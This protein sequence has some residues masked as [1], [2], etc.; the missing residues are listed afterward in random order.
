LLTIAAAALA[1]TL[2][3]TSSL[4]V[5]TATWTVM[6]G[7]RS[8]GSSSS[9]VMKDTKTG[10]AFACS[11]S[12]LSATFKSGSGL[13]GSDLG[14]VTS[15]SATR[16]DA[17]A[18]YGF[19]FSDLPYVFSASSYSS[20]TTTGRITGIHAMGTGPGCTFVMDGTGATADN[21]HMVVTYSN[22]T[23][24]V[25]FSS[26]GNLHFYDVSG[27]YGLLGSGDYANPDFTQPYKLSTK[28]TIT[29]P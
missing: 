18:G 21:G 25:Q 24:D 2:G 19:T 29:S 10:G 17:P 7:G 13:P 14:S 28:Q 9:F 5:T 20:G 8:S 15:I 4:A 27:C 16:C 1:T 6:P 22:S 3:A 12:S 26:G 11:S 23:G